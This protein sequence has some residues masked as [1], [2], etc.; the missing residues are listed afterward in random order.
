MFE[1]VIC[2]DDNSVLEQTRQLIDNWADSISVP[3]TVKNN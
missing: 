2:D 1:I 3:V